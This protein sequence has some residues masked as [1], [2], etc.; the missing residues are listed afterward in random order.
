MRIRILV[1]LLGLVLMSSS[2]SA[3]PILFTDRTAFDAFVG[4]TTLLS[5]DGAIPVNHF[6]IQG[7]PMASVTI[8]NLLASHVVDSEYFNPGPGGFGSFCFCSGFG[9][10][11]TYALHTIEPVFAIGMDITP[12]EPNALFSFGGQK[13]LLN[14]SQFLG[15]VTDQPTTQTFGPSFNA[16]LGGRPSRFTVDNVAIKTVPEPSSLLL[17]GAALVGMF[18]WHYR[19]GLTPSR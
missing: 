13:F 9:V 1:V 11:D 10:G 7:I 17:L 15:I 3:S 16:L 12:L 19:G 2:V 6:Q 4:Q 18:V 14:S 8:D 5:F